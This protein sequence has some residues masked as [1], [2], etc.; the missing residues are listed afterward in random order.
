MARK[1]AG[2]TRRVSDKAAREAGAFGTTRSPSKPSNK[3]TQE[4]L[5]PERD[6]GGRTPGMATWAAKINATWS[7]AIGYFFE[8]GDLLVAAKKELPHGEFLPMIE[9]HLLFGPRTAQR[10]MEIA[11]SES[12]KCVRRTH[13][14]QLPAH[15]TTLLVLSKLPAEKLTELIESGEVHPELE[16]AQ[17]ELLISRHIDP[18]P[19]GAPSYG[20]K[21]PPASGPIVN[22]TKEP[23]P[24]GKP[25]YVSL[26]QKESY[27]PQELIEEI[28]R[29]AAAE[30]PDNVTQLH[31]RSDWTRPSRHGR[32]AEHPPAKPKPKDRIKWFRTILVGIDEVIRQASEFNADDLND[33]G[34]ELAIRAKALMDIE[35]A[36]GR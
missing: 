29:E 26:S 14:Y 2:R 8:T 36:G 20:P 1:G 7:R 27:T 22:L 34:A 6:C 16:R 5:P 18:G 9:K 3:S 31:K 30:L 21:M 11:E 24:A 25:K 15:R 4:I 33:F 12:L 10:L 35:G 19:L 32:E 17:A 13:L 28:E 23:E